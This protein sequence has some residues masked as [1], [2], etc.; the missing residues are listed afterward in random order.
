MGFIMAW[1]Y[2]D[3]KY[4]I[5]KG[6]RLC[7]VSRILNYIILNFFGVRLGFYPKFLPQ[8]SEANLVKS[9]YSNPP[10]HRASRGKAK[11]HGKSG[12]R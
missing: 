6:Q 4:I 7:K 3:N 10:I 1:I 11:M 8:E 9:Y 2:G 5:S 12:A